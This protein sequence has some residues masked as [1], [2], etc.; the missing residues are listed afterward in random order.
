MNEEHDVIVVGAGAAGLACAR[1]LVDGGRAPLVLERADAVG[2]RIRTDSVEGFRLDHGF[3]VLP[4]AYPEARSTLDF[5]RL[6]LGEFERGAI[7]RVDG[8]FRRVAD[9]IR[10]PIRG[11]RAL[12]G[13]VVGVRDGAALVRLSRGS[14]D[15]TTAAEALRRA[16][17]SRATTERILAPLLRGVFLDEQLTTSSRLLDFV[18]R[19]FV[20][21]AAALPEGGIGSITEQLAEGVDVRTRTAVATVGPHAVSLESGET[22]RAS[23]VVVATAGIIDEPAHGWNGVSCVYFD[24]PKPP[25]SGPWL[26]LDGGSGPINNLCVPSEVSAGYAPPDRALVSLTILGAGEPDLDAVRRQLRGWFGTATAE[27][28]H[29]RTYRIPRALPA[30]PVGG[31]LEQPTR[32]APGLFA[33]GDHRLHPSLN[34]ALASGRR[35]AEA[36]L[37]DTT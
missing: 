3:Q 33:C 11:I 1:R 26:V 14:D 25:I 2:G 17:V 5:A 32:L 22:L 36:V 23:A 19:T 20:G 30:Y 34:G 16:G 28:R 15:E 18:L 8:R 21:G 24:A 7:V 35:A 27:W 9:P 29:L 6:R 37:A 13:G 31:S 10:S 4:L 12:A